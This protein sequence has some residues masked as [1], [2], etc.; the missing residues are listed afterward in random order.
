M[1]P[2]SRTVEVPSSRIVIIEGTYAL[3][4]RLRPL[5]DLRVSVTGGIH[6][7]LV[8]RV[9]R[10]IQRAGKE[11]E[12]I[13]HQI[14]ETVY[15]MYKAYIEPDLQTA[16]IKIINKFN[17]F[18]GFQSPTY[19]LKSA[20]KV[21]VDQ[22]K[23][24]LS[25]DF[26]ETTE[27]TYD[28][29]LLP[30]GEDPESCQSYLRMRNKDGKYSLMFEEWVTD[31][32]FVISPRITFPVSVR[33]LGGLMALGYTIATILKRN[34]HVLSD[35]RVCVKLDWLEKLNRHYV[36]G[37]DRLVVMYLA[38]QIG[39]EGS[40]IPRTYIEQ[41]KLEKLVNEAMAMPDDLRMKLS[42]DENLI[43]SSHQEARYRASTDGVPMRHKRVRSDIYQSC[44][45][46][47]DNN[48]DQ[49]TGYDSNN[50]G[51]NERI[52]SDSATKLA[53]LGVITQ[54]SEQISSLNDR[55]D[56]FTNR[57]EE[58]NSK[59]TTIKK[60][61][62]SQ[63]NMATQVECCNGSAPTSY[64]ITSLSNGSLTGSIMPNSSSPSHLA[65]E[66]PLIDEEPRMGEK[67]EPVRKAM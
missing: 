37:R 24:V 18:N 3:S 40:Y 11:P 65:K 33:L 45:N 13:I 5:L 22:I 2:V 66:S 38:Q 21:T 9:I 32:P 64:F 19:I 25:E 55:M 28:I 10:D 23:A 63:H 57:L 7:D 41:I 62:P 12:E 16:H 27:Q 8:K 42:L 1:Y 30:P 43:S 15:P 26:E 31:N 29:Y 39:L 34:S 56:E 67:A 49:V 17:P 52:K 20:R 50:R 35:D 36:Q 53:N 61:C 47:E 4:E 14:S 54:L 44:T 6:F 60:N 48:Q 58:L 46:P 59:L 51:L